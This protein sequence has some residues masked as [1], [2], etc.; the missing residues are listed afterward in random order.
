MPP[1][2]YQTPS[3]SFAYGTGPKELLNKEYIRPRAN[4][5]NS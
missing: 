4:M 2:G 5:A 3:P 1:P